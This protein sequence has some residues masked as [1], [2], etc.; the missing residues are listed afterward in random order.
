M[1]I[2]WIAGII[3]ALIV[4][5][6]GW[7]CCHVAGRADDQWDELVRQHEEQEKAKRDKGA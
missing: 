7:A 3:I 6:W 4:M 5:L 2:W 1:S